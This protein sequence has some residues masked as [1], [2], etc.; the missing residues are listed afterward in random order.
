VGG[1]VEL[2]LAE[3]LLGEHRAVVDSVELEGRSHADPADEGLHPRGGD[4][5]ERGNPLGELVEGLDAGRGA[6]VAVADAL[7]DFEEGLVLVGVDLVQD[8]ALLGVVEGDVLVDEEVKLLFGVDVG[9]EVLG[10]SGGEAAGGLAG[11]EVGGESAL[12]KRAT[13]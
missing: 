9:G 7:H 6:V 12:R 2:F 10:G 8:V 5:S 4:G 13:S 1:G 3:A 11:V